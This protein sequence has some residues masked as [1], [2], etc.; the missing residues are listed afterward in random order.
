MF[1]SLS[2]GPLAGVKLFGLSIFDF[3]DQLCS[4]WLLPLGGLLFTLFVGWYMSKDDVRDEFTSGGTKNVKLF[5]F[6]YFLMRYFAPVGI[7]IVFLSILL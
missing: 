1:C 7:I 5:G 3:F 4:N 6:M 2:F